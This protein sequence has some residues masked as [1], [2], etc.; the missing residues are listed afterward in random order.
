MT[1]SPTATSAVR[2]R[3][4]R[5]DSAPGSGRCHKPACCRCRQEEPK[6]RDGV[7]C[8]TQAVKVLRRCSAGAELHLPA[9]GSDTGVGGH[10]RGASDLRD[11]CSSVYVA[12]TSAPAAA[13]AKQATPR[14]TKTSIEQNR[15]NDN[16]IFCT[17]V[18][19]GL[20][21]QSVLKPAV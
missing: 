12:V 7:H 14:R 16:K 17:A 10:L 18:H 19:T 21:N 8:C 4:G 6:A 13:P 15:T 11:E 2:V 9:P 20:L 5:W 1:V 3:E